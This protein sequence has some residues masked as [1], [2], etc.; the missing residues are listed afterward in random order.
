MVMQ[1]VKDI[2]YFLERTI[3][4]KEIKIEKSSFWQMALA[5]LKL[6]LTAQVKGQLK[7][8]ILR[9]IQQDRI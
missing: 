9:L 8:G 2:F 6:K 5:L 7:T 3:L 1:S 4:I